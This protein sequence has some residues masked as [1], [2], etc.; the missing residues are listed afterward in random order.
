[1]KHPNKKAEESN[2][3]WLKFLRRL[4]KL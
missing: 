2:K 1:M 3:W 4:K